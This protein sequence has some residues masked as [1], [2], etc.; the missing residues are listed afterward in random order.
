MLEGSCRD[1]LLF[2]ASLHP[3]A[4]RQKIFGRLAKC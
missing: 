4:F 3:N 2:Q 1:S